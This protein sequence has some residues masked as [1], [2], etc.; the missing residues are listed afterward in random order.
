MSSDYAT[1]ESLINELISLKNTRFE[2]G[3]SEYSSLTDFVKEISKKHR[4][5]LQAYLT[6][7]SRT[8]QCFKFRMVEK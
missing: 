3:S 4:C 1:P 2:P 7:P 6:G 5:P 8:V